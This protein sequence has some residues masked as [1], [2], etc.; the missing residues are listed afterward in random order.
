MPVLLKMFWKF[1][2]EGNPK[3]ILEGQYNPDAKAK[4]GHN[5]K[6]TR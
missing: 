3:L 6:T 1:E 2:E 4:E 5:K